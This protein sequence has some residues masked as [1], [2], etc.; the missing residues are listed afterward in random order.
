MRRAQGFV[1]VLAIFLIVTLAAV[2][3]YLVTVSTGQS[4]A[5]SQDVAGTRAYQA[6]RAGIEWGTYRRLISNS[7]VNAPGTAVALPGIPG[8]CAVVVCAQVGTT[9]TEGSASISV[10]RVTATGCN[11]SPCNTTACSPGTPGPT[12]VERQLQITITQ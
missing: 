7:C 9:E 11:G 5:I 6:A 12:Y 4:Q 3:V 2:G 1:L 8:Y 10:Y